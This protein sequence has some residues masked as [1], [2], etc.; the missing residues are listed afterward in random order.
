M[1][2]FVAL[3]FAPQSLISPLGAI[4]LVSNAVVAPLVNREVVRWT[5]LVGILLI[6]GGAV[7]ATVFAGAVHE[8]YK[9][10]VL[11]ALFKKPGNIAF[12]AVTG[13]A[14][15]GVWA[16]IILVER[17]LRLAE[18]AA[19]RRQAERNAANAAQNS[20]PNEN[21]SKPNEGGIK[22]EEISENKT[23]RRLSIDV[24]V[25]DLIV[26]NAGETSSHATVGTDHSTEP[27]LRDADPEQPPPYEAAT[28]NVHIIDRGG[29]IVRLALPFAYASIGGR[30]ASLTVLFGKIIV[31][32]L[33]ETFVEGDNQFDSFESWIILIAALIAAVLQVC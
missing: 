9:L 33:S 29:P 20:S 13:G 16:F 7:I 24:V 28:A 3:R 19:R 2:T 6:C 15:I 8:G 23:A 22:M 26:S 21:D 17:R 31:Y 12:M 5:D 10:C 18:R 11:I 14:I 4:S 32:L 30:L 27:A 25:E 1:S